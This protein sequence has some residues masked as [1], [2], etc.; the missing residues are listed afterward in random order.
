MKSTNQSFISVPKKRP[1]LHYGI[2][3]K[4]IEKKGKKT[5]RVPSGII[6][7]L[8]SRDNIPPEI[9]CKD[10]EYLVKGNSYQCFAPSNLVPDPIRQ[11]WLQPNLNYSPREHP[12]V[13]NS[14][15]RCPDFAKRKIKENTIFVR[16]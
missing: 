9:Y 4:R 10:C 1:T 2:L 7:R 5:R 14:K 11:N 12:R 6:R 13:K 15:N 3:S 8:I 16:K